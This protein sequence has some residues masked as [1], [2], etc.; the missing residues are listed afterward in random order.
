MVET[1]NRNNPN[2]TV[3]KDEIV[4]FS[5]CSRSG[6]SRLEE[7]ARVPVIP[8]TVAYCFILESLQPTEDFRN[9]HGY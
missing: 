7:F 5:V 3:V 1:Y 4:D 8:R 9:W 6:G 2:M